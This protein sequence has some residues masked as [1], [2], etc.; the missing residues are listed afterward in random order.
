M[1]ST[2]AVLEET[3]LT[4]AFES[5][6]EPVRMTVCRFTAYNCS[7]TFYFDDSSMQMFMGVLAHAQDT[8]EDI[9]SGAELKLPADAKTVT[10]K[11]VIDQYLG[12]VRVNYPLTYSGSYVR[13][14]YEDGTLLYGYV[15]D[16]L[17]K[18]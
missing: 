9:E 14:E 8:N 11:A 7:E 2:L 5:A 6:K 18:K 3:S 4:D 13:F 10:D 12:A 16:R 17:L 15:P 1:K